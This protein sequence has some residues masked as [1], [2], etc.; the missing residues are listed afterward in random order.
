V[1]GFGL[2]LA[3]LFV[4][5]VGQLRRP[6]SRIA[7]RSVLIAALIDVALLLAAGSVLR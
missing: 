6:A 3:V 7:F 2:A 1:A 5:G 4:G